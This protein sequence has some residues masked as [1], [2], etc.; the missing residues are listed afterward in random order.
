MPGCYELSLKIF[1]PAAVNKICIIFIAQKHL[2]IVY[3]QE[4]TLNELY[5][6]TTL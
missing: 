3:N 6:T 5:F 2:E 1:E 4:T